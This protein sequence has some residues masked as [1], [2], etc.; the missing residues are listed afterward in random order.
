MSRI[1]EAL[2]RASGAY[3]GRTA[4]RASESALKLAEEVPLD[5]YLTE[6]P[7]QESVRARPSVDE[8]TSGRPRLDVFAERPLVKAT[9]VPESKLVI[10]AEADAASVEQYRRLAATLHEAQVEKGLKTLMVTSAGPGDGKTLT[11]VNL[12]L[13]LSGSYGR[14]VLLIDGDLR[15]AAIHSVL[16]LSNETGLSDILLNAGAEPRILDVTP[17]LS[18]VTAG[19]MRDNA[20]AGLASERMSAFLEAAVKRFDWV[21]LDSPPVGLISDAQ[22]LSQQVQGVIFV[23]RA[24]STPFAL[25][26]K[27]LAALGRDRVVGTVLNGVSY[28]EI[29]G[30]TYYGGYA[31]YYRPAHNTLRD[32]RS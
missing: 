9:I 31:G 11:V 26:E 20:Q 5:Q 23:I 28:T 4:G 15:R 18:V 21:L 7:A 30:T 24:G 32:E 2:K 12:G 13:T 6:A 25:V 10:G 17:K 1:D 29:P 3:P 22:I 16:G 14:R 19:P 27:A 8:P